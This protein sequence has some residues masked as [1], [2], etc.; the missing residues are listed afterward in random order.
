MDVDFVN[1]VILY[2]GVFFNG[3][4]II[5]VGVMVGLDV[6]V[7]D[8][9]IC[10]EVIVICFEVIFVVVGE[11]VWVGLFFNI[12]FGFV[13]DCDVKV[14][15][16]VEIKN[17]YIGIEVVIFYMV[18]VGDFEVIVGFFI[19]VGFVFFW[20]CVVFVIVLDIMFDS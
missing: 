14:G 13:F 12:C 8:F 15:V 7:I 18:Y 11:G 19:V 6:I 5:G 9:E 2:F 16:F 1:D 17:I 4:I 10:E 20:E 3:V